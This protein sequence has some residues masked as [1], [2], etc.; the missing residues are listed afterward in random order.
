MTALLSLK[1]MEG[2]QKKRDYKVDLELLQ[3]KKIAI[4]AEYL[5]RNLNVRADLVS[6]NTQDSSKWYH[7]LQK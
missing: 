7:C 3:I 2:K 1:K 6:T 5:P 4:T